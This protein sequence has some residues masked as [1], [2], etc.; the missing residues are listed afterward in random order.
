MKQQ[1]LRHLSNNAA[2]ERHVVTIPIQA[3]IVG[4]P[5]AGKGTLS[6]RLT[7]DFGFQSLSSGDAF[8]AHI[9]QGT[10]L[11]KEAKT[12]I[13]QGDLVPDSVTCS[14]ML[15][16]ITTEIEKGG[17]LL[18]DGFPR[19]VPQAEVI[20]NATSIDIV[21]HLNVPDEEI[22]ERMTQRR[23]HPGSGRIYHLTFNPPKVDGID[24]ETGEPLV[25]REDDKAET[26][27]KRL[28]TYHQETSPIIE[29]Y[30]QKGLV[31]TFTG[32]ESNEIYPRMAAFVRGWKKGFVSNI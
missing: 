6:K 30:K 9:G 8:R 12:F 11:G 19:T 16:T 7:E 22:I 23:L 29:H 24:D 5:G 31:E 18:L 27:L 20:D 2:A 1:L 28:E 17:S 25:I 21:L 15:A 4:P 32:T 10:D 13:D 14:L 26:V 3:L